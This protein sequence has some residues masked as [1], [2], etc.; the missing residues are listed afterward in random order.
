MTRTATG[1]YSFIASLILFL[2]ALLLAPQTASAQDYHTCQGKQMTI[3]TATGMKITTCN[4][5]LDDAPI[6]KTAAGLETA[7]IPGADPDACPCRFTKFSS[8]R[9]KQFPDSRACVHLNISVNDFYTLIGQSVSSG[10]I[11]FFQDLFSVPT[12]RCRIGVTATFNVQV[13]G[14]SIAQSTAC[15]NAIKAYELDHDIVPAGQPTGGACP[16]VPVP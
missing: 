3:F 5:D 16:A 1:N 8:N 6:N 4:W 13:F 2:G 15:R 7:R 11:I 12:K 14:L 10:H 9:W